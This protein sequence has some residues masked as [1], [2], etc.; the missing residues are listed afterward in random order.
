M[1][2]RHGYRSVEESERGPKFLTSGV[3]GESEGQ[4]YQLSQQHSWHLGDLAC[5]QTQ[6][7]Q[8]PS[9]HPDKAKNNNNLRHMK[10]HLKFH[11]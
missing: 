2:L 4:A 8:H 6:A 7:A 9:T 11:F 1:N 10:Q 5:L 3:D